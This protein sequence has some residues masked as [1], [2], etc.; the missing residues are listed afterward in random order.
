MHG[1]RKR[2]RVGQHELPHVLARHSE[3][4]CDVSE[5]HQIG[6]HFNQFGTGH[7]PLHIVQ[8][9]TQGSPCAVCFAAERQGQ[10]S[11]QPKAHKRVVT[12]AFGQ[13]LLEDADSLPVSGKRYFRV[14]LNSMIDPFASDEA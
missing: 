2:L 8:R 11:R 13:A 9:R 1:G 7:G 12:A 5:P 3:Q 4:V 14:K 10:P 6:A